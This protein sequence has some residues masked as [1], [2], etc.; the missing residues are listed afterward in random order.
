MAWVVLTVL[1]ILWAIGYAVDL[2]GPAIHLLLVAAALVFA[3]KV[4]NSRKMA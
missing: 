3:V 4:A 1:V 2:S